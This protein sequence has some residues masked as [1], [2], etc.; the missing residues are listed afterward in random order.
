[1]CELRANTE[2]ERE[3]GK[4]FNMQLECSQFFEQFDSSCLG[5]NLPC[6][7]L[8]AEGG[9]SPTLW[10]ISFAKVNFHACNEAMVRSGATSGVVCLALRIC[11]D[12]IIIIIERGADLVRNCKTG[13]F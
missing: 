10:S 6:S 5:T 1:M 12:S 2:L 3:L 7:Y 11:A 8:H 13:F 9:N 4:S